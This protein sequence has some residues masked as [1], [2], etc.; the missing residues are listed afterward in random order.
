METKNNDEKLD[1]I[2]DELVC[3]KE[4]QQDI[5][6]LLLEQNNKIN[7]INDKVDDV[8]SNVE[9]ANQKIDKIDKYTKKNKKILS[10][11]IIVGSVGITIPATVIFGP[12][13]LIGLTPIVIAQKFI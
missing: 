5:N 4:I 1:K 7:D 2:L 9:N 12:L 10:T 8:K 11:A 3:M 13:G 6:S